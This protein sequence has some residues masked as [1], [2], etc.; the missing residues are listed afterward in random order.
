MLGIY[1]EWQEF[2]VAFPA[3]GASSRERNNVDASSRR[4]HVRASPDIE[5]FHASRLIT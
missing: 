4:E 5:T 1:I 2:N 3:W